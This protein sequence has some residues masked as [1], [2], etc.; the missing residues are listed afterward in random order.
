MRWR[1]DKGGCCGSTE[2]GIVAA[3]RSWRDI[4]CR[5]WGGI[6]P[7]KGK[8]GQ[9]ERNERKGGLWKLTPL[10][11][12]RP[13]HGFPQ[14]LEKSLAKNARLFHSSHRPGGGDHIQTCFRNSPGGGP[15]RMIKGGP[16]SVDE[17]M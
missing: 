15:N 2:L 8:R 9:N 11:E 1:R 12:I 10:M 17:P 13:P 5:K 3:R 16:V 4:F 6:G 7:K 14:R